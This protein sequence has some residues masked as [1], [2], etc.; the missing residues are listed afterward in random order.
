MRDNPWVGIVLGVVVAGLVHTGKSLARPAVNVSTVGLATPVVS[1]AEDV[2]SV[3]L[4]LVAIFLPLLV[5]VLVALLGWALVAIA[6]RV[7]RRRAAG[8][9]TAR[10]LN[11]L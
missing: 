5:I 10:N 4:S 7:R 1:A 6:R 3:S 8:A 2:T 9:A 11:A